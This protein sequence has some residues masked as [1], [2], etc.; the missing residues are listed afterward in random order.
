VRWRGDRDKPDVNNRGLI[1]NFLFAINSGISYASA[2][3]TF[4][5]FLDN[6][7]LAGYLELAYLAKPRFSSIQCYS[8]TI[9]IRVLG[10]RMDVSFLLTNLS[11]HQPY[12]E[13]SRLII[14]IKHI[15]MTIFN[16]RTGNYTS[17][18]L[19]CKLYSITASSFTMQ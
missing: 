12:H 4:K 16:Y 11:N 5:I 10:F 15:F 19:I 13:S 7:R 9:W 14:I 8:R 17:H 2:S 1:V 18:K 6:C 3:G